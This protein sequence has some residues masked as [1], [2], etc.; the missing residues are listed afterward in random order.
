M[1]AAPN[2]EQLV[3]WLTGELA[4]TGQRYRIDWAAL[5]I[6]S[7]REAQRLLR[8]LGYDKLAEANRERRMPWKGLR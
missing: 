1:T 2:K 5:D 7:L 8:D 4:R 3:R 6:T